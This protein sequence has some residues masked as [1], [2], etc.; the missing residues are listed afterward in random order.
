MKTNILNINGEKGKEISVPSF[1]SQPVRE[2]LIFKVLESKKIKQP[3]SPAPEAGKRHSAS[4]IIIHRR[5]VW[6]TGYGIGMSRVPRKVMSRRGT[7]FNWIGAEVAGT[8]GGRRA[9]PP[10][11]NSM[12]TRN[13]I[14]KKEMKIALISALSASAN[15][16]EIQKKY[17]TLRNEKIKNLPLIVESKITSLKTK[18]MINSLKK[19][20]GNVFD[21]AL[22]K[23]SV[24]S[25][26]GKMR[27]RK[28]KRT[29]GLLIVTGEK[30]EMKVSGVDVRRAKNLSVTDLASGGPGRIVVYT[31]QAVKDLEEK[32]K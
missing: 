10:R 9:H 6:K 19:I 7:R 21:V 4:G 20:L 13:K 25:G 27:G 3:H 12:L 5:K 23:K 28:Y 22:Q 1:F 14:N 8:V 2:D 24:R 32:L 18:E 15:E 16:R 29:A 17:E 30:E 26:K 11:V 31:E